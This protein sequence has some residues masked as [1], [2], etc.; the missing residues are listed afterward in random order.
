M[1]MDGEIRN[2]V[3]FLSC[4]ILN[5]ISFVYFIPFKVMPKK[6]SGLG[7]YP[8]PKSFFGK[9]PKTENSEQ[10]Q[11]KGGKGLDNF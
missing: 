9:F 8:K 10:E 3:S 1:G 5:H 11:P 2:L 6:L 4:S 7:N